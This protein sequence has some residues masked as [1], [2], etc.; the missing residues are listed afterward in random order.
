MVSKMLITLL[1]VIEPL[2]AAVLPDTTEPDASLQP[3]AYP[4]VKLQDIF[5]FF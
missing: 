1:E 3:S 2:M 4:A 5:Y